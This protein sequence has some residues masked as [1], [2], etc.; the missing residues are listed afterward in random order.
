MRV[1]WRAFPRWIVR[2]EPDGGVVEPRPVLLYRP[3]HHPLRKRSGSTTRIEGGTHSENFSCE[4]VEDIDE[5]CVNPEIKPGTPIGTY[6][7][8]LRVR[9]FRFAGGSAVDMAVRARGR[10]MTGA[11]AM[12]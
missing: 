9:T 3:G 5:D 11:A 4:T 8:S 1:I 6:L 10:G 7:L 2:R 12:R